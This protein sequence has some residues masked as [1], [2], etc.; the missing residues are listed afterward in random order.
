M[1]NS[2]PA[3]VSAELSV[4]CGGLDRAYSPHRIWIHRDGNVTTPD[5]SVSLDTDA[6]QVAYILQ[7]HPEHT[8]GYWRFIPQMVKESKTIHLPNVET[9]HFV[10]CDLWTVKATWTA[11]SG[12]LGLGVHTGIDPISV[13][14]YVKVY[15]SHGKIPSEPLTH[16][17]YLLTPW[18][19]EGG[20]RR[21]RATTPEELNSLLVAGIPVDRAAS[22]AALDIDGVTAKEVVKHLNQ[23]GLPP[24]TILQL[25]YALPPRQIPSL[26]DHLDLEKGKHITAR[27]SALSVAL[28]ENPTS[29]DD[30]TSFL[31]GQ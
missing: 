24:D 16:L 19:R 25:S 9:W 15:Q 27:L 23:F 21:S 1:N 7:N 8:C 4:Q 10:E 29:V 14:E 17:E 12:L 6:E 20:H 13:L 11:V 18:I 31:L 26:L 28:K 30:V 5:H 22:A 2:I 3:T